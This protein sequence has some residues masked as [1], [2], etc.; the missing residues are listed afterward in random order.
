VGVNDYISAKTNRLKAMNKPNIGMAI[1]RVYPNAVMLLSIYT[2]SYHFPSA[3]T[4]SALS[5]RTLP[6]QDKRILRLP[7]RTSTIRPGHT[8]RKH[9]RRRASH[10]LRST[11]VRRR[12]WKVPWRWN[13]AWRRHPWLK[14]HPLRWAAS[15]WRKRWRE[16]HA[17]WRRKGHV[18][19]Q[20]RDRRSL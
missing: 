7:G 10:A 6:S 5:H 11:T 19:R 9:A 16:R 2:Y 12:E 4:E 1:L 14:R 18:G 13:S 20:P 8:R 17:S 15:V 3:K